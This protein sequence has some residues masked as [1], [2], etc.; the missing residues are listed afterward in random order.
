MMWKEF[1]QIAGYE[2]SYE[3]Y[4]NIIEPMYMAIPDS[5]SKADFVKMIDRK[6]FALPTKAEIRRKLKKEMR[7]EADH[8]ADICGHYTDFESEQRLE[9]L[10]RE[11]AKKICGYKD[12]D[13][14]CWYG[15]EREYEYE[16][17]RG[18]SYPAVFRVGYDRTVLEEIVLHA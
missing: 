13:F 17:M 15:F 10:A 12:D 7:K 2:V 11:Y 14:K 6:R 4:T 16:G 3:D 9:K 18:C 1:E 8:L 5:F